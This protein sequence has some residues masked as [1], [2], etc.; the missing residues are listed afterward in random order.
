MS[1]G[2]RA[3]DLVTDFVEHRDCKD[4]EQWGGCDR[5][6]YGPAFDEWE[7]LQDVNRIDPHFHGEELDRLRAQILELGG[8]LD[9]PYEEAKNLTVIHRD[10][11]VAWHKEQRAA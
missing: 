9:M 3:I 8:T 4:A 6:H 7:L 10:A 1:R 11:L 2:G 5:A